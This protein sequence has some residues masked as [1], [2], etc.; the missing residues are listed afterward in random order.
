VTPSP[1]SLSTPLLYYSTVTEENLNPG[2][3][4]SIALPCT[5][6]SKKSGSCM[7]MATLATGSHEDRAKRIPNSQKNNRGGKKAEKSAIDPK[8]GLWEL[9]GSSDLVGYGRQNLA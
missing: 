2:H 4:Y 1:L 5:S 6:E 3:S 8:A 9:S 7:A